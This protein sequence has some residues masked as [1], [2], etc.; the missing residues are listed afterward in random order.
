MPPRLTLPLT[1]TRSWLPISLA[2]SSYLIEPLPVRLDML[3]VPTEVP[4]VTDP[5]LNS[6]LPALPVPA[7]MPPLL[8]V[9][10]IEGSEALAISVPSTETLPPEGIAL[11]PASVK[12]LPDLTV[13]PP[14]NVLA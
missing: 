10:L 13:V 3:I 8:I 14:V 7:R 11:L 6:T 12:V 5:E 1:L 9:G 4:G 2:G